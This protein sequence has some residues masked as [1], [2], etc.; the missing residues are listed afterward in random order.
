MKIKSFLDNNTKKKKQK[1]DLEK[2]SIQIKINKNISKEEF[3][4]EIKLY[5][6]YS[7]LSIK[8]NIETELY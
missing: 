2:N 5:L 8:A 1:S 4:E 7:T 6:T 3:I